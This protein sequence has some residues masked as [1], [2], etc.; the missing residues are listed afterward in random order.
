MGRGG[1]CATSRS[2]CQAGAHKLAPEPVT[3]PGR[4][5]TCP[6]RR[7]IVDRRLPAIMNLL[8]LALV[9]VAAASPFSHGDTSVTADASLRLIKVSE[10]DPGT[11]VREDEK[12]EKYV[13]KGIN[14]V[15]VTDMSVGD[16]SCG[17]GC[18]DA[19]ADLACAHST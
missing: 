16:P 6:A 19:S 12:I 5:E 13:A 4:L 14:F 15:D 17:A 10:S 8:L 7:Y 9:G 3:S 2:T 18:L 1:M 11:W